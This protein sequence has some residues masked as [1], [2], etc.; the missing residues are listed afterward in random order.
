MISPVSVQMSRGYLI[1]T[2]L[3]IRHGLCNQFFQASEFLIGNNRLFIPT[4]K[5]FDNIL[6]FLFTTFKP[7]KNIF[8]KIE[9]KNKFV[10]FFFYY[11]ILGRLYE[12]Y[13]DYN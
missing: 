8:F 10:Y 1:Q 4:K 5:T 2:S 11:I 3:L 9:D 12:Y 7:Q 6:F 13:S